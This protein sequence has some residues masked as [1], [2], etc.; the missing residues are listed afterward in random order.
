ME[1]S[2]QAFQLTIH[3]SPFGKWGH[4]VFDLKDQSANVLGAL[5]L[6]EL[7][8]VVTF[9]QTSP[10]Q[11]LILSSAKKTG[12]V[13]GADVTEFLDHFKKDEAQMRAWLTSINKTFNTFEDLPFPKVALVN[14]FALGGGFELALLTEYRLGTPEAVV[15]LP[16]TKL[17]IIPGWGGTVRL[18]RL[19]GADHA[20]E[21]ITQGRSIKALEA[22]KFG[23]IDAVIEAEKALELAS[24]FLTRVIS[25]K[26]N[27]SQKR[28]QK[29][30][31]LLLS[32]TESMMTFDSAMGMVVAQLGKNYPAPI[33]AVES[34]HRGAKLTRDEALKI[35]TELFAKMT[36]TPQASALVQVFLNEQ[37][38]KKKAKTLSGK[39]PVPQK[40]AV[41]GAGI[42]GGGIAYQALSQGLKVV[43][44]DIAQPSLDIGAQEMSKLF[45]KQV[46]QKKLT[47][48]KLTLTMANYTATLEVD[49]L[50]SCDALIEAVVENPQVKTK[51]LTEMETVLPAGSWLSS[52]TSTI[53]ITML[54]KALKHP[55]NFVGMHFFNPVH[56]MPL[57]EI[58]RGE[59]SSP[60]AVSKG[61]ALSLKMGKT[62][63]VVNDCA[64]FLVNRV[65][66]PYF[67]GFLHL[68][69]QGSD[70]LEVDKV[71]EKWGWPMGPAYLLD[72]VGLD[73]AHHAS[74]IMAQAF[75]DRM[76]FQEKNALDLLYKD[77]KFGQKSGEGFYLYRPDKKG[78]PQKVIDDTK[79]PLFKTLAKKNRTFT[80]QEIERGL[81]LPLFFE[82][83]RCLHEKIVETPMEL[84]MALLMGL[85]FPPFRTGIL[86][87]ADQTGLETLY[88]DSL[89]WV[90]LG[91]LYAF[92]DFLKTR[93]EQK[94]LFYSSEFN[95]NQTQ[96]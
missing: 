27:W 10:I 80:T 47:P 43:V 19:I 96:G 70:Y 94:K 35:E 30:Q 63:I 61:V 7:A 32:K 2:G 55:E 40:C 6:K 20:L 87:W 69:N 39:A 65:L 14:G 60:D 79:A 51:V 64:G 12:F 92:P 18:P 89:K 66:F 16:E 25:E 68:L 59:K 78:R 4:L 15:G 56:R 42:M 29:K 34:L 22:L 75:P 84:D 53:S 95:E 81:L 90:E 8:E 33:A 23:A 72:V 45:Q 73:T 26:W 82:A 54:A 38:V 67:N 52:N 76:S 37:F 62:P 24:Q 21:W 50:K 11:G 77:K 49:A 57:V 93:L 44:K 3:Q 46:E 71:M 31:P 58:I 74:A 41:L 85:G 5:A 88:Q 9:L 36:Q 83:A 1:F 86:K 48:E 91:N 17:G 28:E 13:L